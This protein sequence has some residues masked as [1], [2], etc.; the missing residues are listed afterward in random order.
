MASLVA[1]Q[2]ITGDER[3]L[4]NPVEE[5]AAV[6]LGLSDEYLKS[7]LSK[8]LDEEPHVITFLWFVCRRGNA[9]YFKR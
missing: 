6:A 5:L 2:S 8:Q 4:A 3:G 7:A 9:P 1:S